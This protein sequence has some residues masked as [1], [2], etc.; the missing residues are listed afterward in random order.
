M[1]FGTKFVVDVLRIFQIKN[2]GRISVVILDFSRSLQTISFE[3]NLPALIR[4]SA[5]E[6]GENGLRKQTGSRPC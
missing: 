1:T 3:K 5:L 6:S 2:N 4:T